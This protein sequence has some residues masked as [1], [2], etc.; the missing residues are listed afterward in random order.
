MARC[1]RLETGRECAGGAGGGGDV[2]TPTTASETAPTW[3][4]A[5]CP[6]AFRSRAAFTVLEPQLRVG[7]VASGTWRVHR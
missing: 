7:G 2:L 3:G 5:L 1:V 4:S 6:G